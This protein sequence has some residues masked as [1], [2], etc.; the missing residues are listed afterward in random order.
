MMSSTQKD[1][2]AADPLDPFAPWKAL[3]DVSMDTWSKAMVDFVNSDEYASASAQWLNTYL[4]MSKSFQQVV[5]QAI[6]QTLNQYNIP[7]TADVPRLAERLTNIEFRLDDLDAHL[8]EVLSLVRRLTESAAATEQPS[9][10][11]AQPAKRGERTPVQAADNAAG[12]IE[13]AAKLISRR[14][15]ASAGEPIATGALAAASGESAT[16]TGAPVVGS[17]RAGAK[18]T[19]GP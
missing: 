4:T 16:G 8:D 17:R 19:K 7:T 11:A 14:A 18:R 5:D 6:A 15:Q 9:G 12:A 10:T 13:E 1:G 3:R 2:S